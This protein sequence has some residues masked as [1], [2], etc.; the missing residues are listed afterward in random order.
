MF[1]YLTL[2]TIVGPTASDSDFDNQGLTAGAR[3]A[4]FAKDFEELGEVTDIAVSIDKML[5]GGATNSN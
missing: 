1:L 4:L 5:E 3:R 2:W